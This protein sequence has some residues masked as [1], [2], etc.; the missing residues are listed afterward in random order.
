M[1]ASFLSWLITSQLELVCALVV[2]GIDAFADS[3]ATIILQWRRRPNGS[4]FREVITKIIGWPFVCDSLTHRM[5][6]NRNQLALIDHLVRAGR[7]GCCASFSMQ[8]DG[9]PESENGG[10]E[11]RLDARCENMDGSEHLGKYRK[12]PC[13]SQPGC[14]REV[15]C[16]PYP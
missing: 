3:P 10:R 12:F 16:A 5:R 1:I 11:S 6:R 7:A 13:N 4:L 2:C 8:I 15:F 14:L 9:L